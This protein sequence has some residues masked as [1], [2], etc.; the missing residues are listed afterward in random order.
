[1]ERSFAHVCET[2]GARRTWARGIEEANKRY[3]ISA[4]AHNLGRL[5]R[6]LFGVWTPK[7]WQKALGLFCL[8]AHPVFC[9]A[10]HPHV[11]RS[12]LAFQK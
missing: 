9:P 12:I 5:M 8:F 4:M 11:P 3:I 7:V 2:G 1:V 10:C 6:A